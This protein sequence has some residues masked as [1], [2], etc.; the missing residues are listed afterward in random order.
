MSRTPG[1]GGL[2][3]GLSRIREQLQRVHVELRGKGYEAWKLSL[4][5]SLEAPT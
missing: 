5:D 1:K 2:E 3:R 4:D